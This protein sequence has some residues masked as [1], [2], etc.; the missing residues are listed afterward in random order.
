MHT[1]L[2]ANNG[3]KLPEIVMR[4][5]GKPGNTAIYIKRDGDTIEVMEQEDL[6]CR[7]SLKEKIKELGEALYREKKGVLYKNVLETVEKPL[8]E[9]ALERSEGNQLK[10]AR[11][12]GLN[13]NTIRAKIKKFGINTMTW[14]VF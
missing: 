2:I 9:Y 13:R 11:I 1:I 5:L 6:R 3:Q 7:V 12:L 14:K 8:I 4:M 10:A